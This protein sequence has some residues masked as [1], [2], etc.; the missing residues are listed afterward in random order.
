MS[1]IFINISVFHDHEYNQIQSFH[2]CIMMTEKV[3]LSHY[4]QPAIHSQVAYGKNSY[5]SE[6]STKLGT[7]V[8]ILILIHNQVW[9]IKKIQYGRHFELKSK[10]AANWSSGI[11]KVTISLKLFK[12]ETWFQCQIICFRGQTIHWNHI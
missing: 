12:V 1:I 2:W 10:M 6:E 11:I 8:N 3:F 4:D 9:A 7:Y 5:R